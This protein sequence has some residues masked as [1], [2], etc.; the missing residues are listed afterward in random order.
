[1]SKNFEIQEKIL[2]EVKEQKIPITLFLMNGFQIQGRVE[3][4]DNFS[5]L[6]NSNGKQQLIYKHAISTI[7]PG[8]KVK[9]KI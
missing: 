9:K 1:M 8:E 6:I 5:I 4:Y 7:V 2:N 3:G